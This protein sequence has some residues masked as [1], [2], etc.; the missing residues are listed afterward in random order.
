MKPDVCSYWTDGNWTV[1]VAPRQWCD[2]DLLTSSVTF[3]YVGVLLQVT[4][5]TYWFSPWWK[6]KEKRKVEKVL[7]GPALTSVHQEI[8]HSPAFF[9]L[10]S[11][12]VMGNTHICQ[13]IRDI[14]SKQR[15]ESYLCS[16]WRS[17]ASTAS[18]SF[19]TL[20]FTV[21]VFFFF[22]RCWNHIWYKP[23]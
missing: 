6:K 13:L 2:N 8:T 22:F 5:F 7:I 23:D 12:V 9:F 11:F 4:H 10:F 19:L 1:S 3:L 16:V 18:L 15:E 20:I 17:L 14:C 21:E